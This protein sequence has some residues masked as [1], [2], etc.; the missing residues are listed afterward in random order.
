MFTSQLTLET[1][2]YRTEELTF[3]P[4]PHPHLRSYLPARKDRQHQGGVHQVQGGRGCCRR[5][6][7]IPRRL[8]PPVLWCWCSDQRHRYSLLQ[9]RRLPRCSHLRCHCC[10]R[11]HLP[12]LRREAS[13]RH[14]RRQRPRQGLRDS[15]SVCLP[16]LVGHPHQPLRVK[17]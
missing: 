17:S 11:L 8:G 3:I 4:S 5:L 13:H 14:R 7:H 1:K 2:A 9:G 15:R 10:S 6:G 12:G 16:H